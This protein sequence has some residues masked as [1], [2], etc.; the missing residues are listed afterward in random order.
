MASVSTEHHVRPVQNTT[1]MYMVM[2]LNVLIIESGVT[3]CFVLVNVSIKIMVVS[4]VHALSIT[5]V[6]E[7]SADILAFIVT[8]SIALLVV[9]KLMTAVYVTHVHLDLK[10]ME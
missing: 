10:V 9:P 1:K 3:K 6:M 2:L 8:P 5:R 4:V 7:L